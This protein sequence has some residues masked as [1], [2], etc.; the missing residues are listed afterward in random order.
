M[1]FCVIAIPL[2]YTR[3]DQYELKNTERI[4]IKKIRPCNERQLH[5]KEKILL[6]IYVLN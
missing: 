3:D 4:L 5:V 1:K 6:T 2:L